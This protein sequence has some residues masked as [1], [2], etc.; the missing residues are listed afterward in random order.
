MST[1]DHW[2]GPEGD[3]YHDRQTVRLEANVQLFERALLNCDFDSVLELG[4]GDGRNLEAL[5]DWDSTLRLAGV[6]VNARALERAARYGNVQRGSVTMPLPIQI[7]PAGLTFTKGLLIHIPPD[8]LAGVYQNLYNYSTRWILIA[9]YYNPT[10]VEVPYRGKAGLLWKRDF[11]GE[12][13]DAYPDLRLV[14]YGFHY[15]RDDYPQ[16]DITFFLLE[17]TK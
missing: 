3:Q 16:D 11:A 15:H 17:K 6:D 10:P 13:M 9:E 7:G 14:D 5:F 12:M 8:H 1:I 2:T 4:C